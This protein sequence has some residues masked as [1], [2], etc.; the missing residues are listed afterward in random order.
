MQTP[1]YQGRVIDLGYNKLPCDPEDWKFAR[2]RTQKFVISN[3][4]TPNGNYTVKGDEEEVAKY[5]KANYPLHLEGRIRFFANQG[6]HVTWYFNTHWIMPEFKKKPNSPRFNQKY[7]HKF[8]KLW[9]K[10]TKEE[11]LL[12]RLP[13]TWLPFLNDLTADY[14]IKY[15]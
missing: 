8:F 1:I 7:S 13:K 6:S 12:R 5:I 3:V 11:H 2:Q 4:I 9:N 10:N 15:Q 14:K